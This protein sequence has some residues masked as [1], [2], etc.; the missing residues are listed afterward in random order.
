MSERLKT[1]FRF[2]QSSLATFDACRRRF[3]LR[4]IRRLE[5]PAALTISDQWEEAILRG[6]RFHQWVEQEGLGMDVTASVEEEEDAL[7]REWW[8]NFREK[9]PAG[10]KEGQI[11]SEIQLTAPLGEFRVLAKFDR[12]SFG[13]EGRGKIFDWKTGRKRPQQAVHAGSWQTVVYRYALVEAGHLLNGGRP[14]APEQVSLVYWHAHFPE[15]LQPIS[16]S[17][18]EH[19]EAGERL[20]KGMGRIARLEGEEAFPKT[21]DREECSRCPFRSFC[22]IPIGPA[23]GVGDDWEIDEEEL[24]WDLIPEAEL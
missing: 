10:I 12:L 11:F 23:E 13:A 6:K 24:N 9:P 22:E 1:G 18:E 19:R 7:L 5:W 3:F 21:E 8:T 2:S 14:L 4:Y 17:P 15:L 16:Y 20:E